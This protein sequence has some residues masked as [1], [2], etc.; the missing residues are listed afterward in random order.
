ML[1]FPCFYFQNF[2]EVICFL[3]CRQQKFAI[4][5]SL[6]TKAKSPYTLEQNYTG[7]SVWAWD[8]NTERLPSWWDLQQTSHMSADGRLGWACHLPLYMMQWRILGV[9]TRIWCK[10][11]SE[12]KVLSIHVEKWFLWS[13]IQW[14]AS[15]LS[16]TLGVDSL[17]QPWCSV[18]FVFQSS[19]HGRF[20]LRNRFH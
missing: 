3:N 15:S 2:P 1:W 7:S 19:F 18:Y 20:Y 6:Q 8:G 14:A 13:R 11:S 12:F 4:L 17:P 10:H 9:F 16:C 5:N